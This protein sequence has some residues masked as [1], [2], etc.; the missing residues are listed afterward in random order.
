MLIPIFLNLQQAEQ[1]P[2]GARTGADV[3]GFAPGR[4]EEAAAARS[5]ASDVDVA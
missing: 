5:A 3:P 2:R 1:L 4:P